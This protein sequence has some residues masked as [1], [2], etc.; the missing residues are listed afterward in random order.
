[1]AKVYGMLISACLI[2][3]IQ[4]AC[5]KW[6]VME[7]SPEMVV[8]VR[9][10]IVAVLWFILAWR[11]DGKAMLPQGKIEWLFVFCLG[12][13]GVLLNNVVQFA[14]IKY[15]TVTNSALIG[16]TSPGMTAVMAFFLIRERLDMAKWLG[17]FLS[18][19]GVLAVIT[20]GDVSLLWQLE[21]NRGDIYCLISQWGWA[22]S[23]FF[24]LYLMRRMSVKAATFW[25]C[26]TGAML[27]GAWGMCSDT[28]IFA[29]LTLR[30][31][32]ALAFVIFLGGFLALYYYNMGVL[33]AG[34][35]KAAVFFNLIPLAG[36]AAG[37]VLFGDVLSFIQVVGA[38]A[39]LA[40]VY[41]TTHT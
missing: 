35:S 7:W 23:S 27:T 33:K 9:Y 12:F 2:W 20:N 30:D 29:P 6:L 11:Q 38:I 14:G 1:M 31:M 28:L 40:G 39:V 37:M 16:A 8:L 41:M 36:I 3:V 24:S 19:V 15:T 17:I 13:F 25:L 22:V 4:P 26:F 34:P 18:F 10:L 32:G 5:I 21:F